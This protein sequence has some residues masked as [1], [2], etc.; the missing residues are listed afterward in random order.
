MMARRTARWYPAQLVTLMNMYT[1][2]N[3]IP[4]ANR[5]SSVIQKLLVPLHPQ[6]C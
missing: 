3:T 1:P 2:T 6:E 5:M 4:V